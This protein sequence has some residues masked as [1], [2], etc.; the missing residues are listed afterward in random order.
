MDSYKKRIAEL[1][2]DNKVVYIHLNINSGVSMFVTNDTM[3]ETMVFKKTQPTTYD[4]TAKTILP[5]D[6]FIYIKEITSYLSTSTVVLY[7]DKIWQDILVV[8]S[9]S[10]AVN[11]LGNNPYEVNCY[12][13]GNLMTYGNNKSSVYPLTNINEETRVKLPETNT[14]IATA[15]YYLASAP[16][17]A[18][19]DVAPD[20][21][22]YEEMLNDVVNLKRYYKQ[23]MS[24]I[25]LGTY[26]DLFKDTNVQNIPLA[27]LRNNGI[28]I[29]CYDNIGNNRPLEDQNIYISLP[30]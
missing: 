4:K 14:D 23:V 29:F 11:A 16:G 24:F 2:I 5:D 1:N 20:A 3:F 15:E 25:K 21:N 26:K 27:L 17:L 12:T 18:A 9:L 8:P 28:R 10:F 13:I 19:P 6:R 22:T 7:Y 30:F